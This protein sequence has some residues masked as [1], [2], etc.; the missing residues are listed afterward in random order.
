MHLYVFSSHRDNSKIYKVAIVGAG[1]AGLASAKKLLEKGC[2]DIIILEALD[3][4]GGRIHTV[5][6][7][8]LHLELGAQWI[9]G[10]DN[11][12]YK[13]AKKF[14]LISE[15]LSDEGQGL[16]I[17]DDGVVFEEDLVKLVDFEVGKILT[18]CQEYL[19][20]KE[21][22]KSVGHFLE[23]EF[24]KYLKQVGDDPE[25]KQKKKE[26]LDWH[27]RFQEI[28]NS[29]IKI[30]NLSAKQ[31]GKYEI[32]Y[33]TQ[34]HINL[35]TGYHSIVELLLKNIPEGVLRLE[36]EVLE[37]NYCDKIV[38]ITCRNTEI[39][40]E[41]VILTSSMGVLKHL[42][43]NIHPGLPQQMQE[44]VDNVGFD[45][46]GKIFLIYKE[47]WWKNIKG[48][49]LL[50]RENAAVD[51]GEEWLRSLT[52]FDELS[53][54]SNVLLGWIGG[55]GVR[56]MEMLSEEQVGIQCT[57][58]LRRFLKK[59]VPDVPLPSNVIK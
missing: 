11:P 25:V 33:D 50:W 28:D 58:L 42:S 24:R 30:K 45:S 7:D 16:Y 6:Y 51:V 39:L 21:Y 37:I 19:G 38:K 13:M 2:E 23:E 44:A 26:L 35:K 40:A 8:G 20:L 4:A 52:G 53:D 56:S 32:D 5:K 1:L 10:K 54:G 36:T 31:W 22:P 12:I 15:E 55:E 48:F 3:K 27:V 59:V 57:L 17:R 47:K 34:A 46:L 41:H 18:T 9:H 43:K 14:D 29:C 49:Q